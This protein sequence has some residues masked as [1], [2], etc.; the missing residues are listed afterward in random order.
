MKPK[1]RKTHKKKPSMPN[2]FWYVAESNTDP[3]QYVSGLDGHGIPTY[4]SDIL[5]A[6]WSDK[7]KIVEDYIELYEI[8]A[9][10]KTMDGGVRPNKPPIT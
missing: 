3:G 2:D 5:D 7:I 4:S 8:N 1:E 6:E 10:A 9:Q